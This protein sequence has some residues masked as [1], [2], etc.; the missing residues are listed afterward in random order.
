MPTVEDLQK[1]EAE[2]RNGHD[3]DADGEG[4][5]IE[6]MEAAGIVPDEDE[7]PEVYLEG[8]TGQLSLS[9]GG[10]KPDSATFKM[11]AK[12]VKLAERTQFA[13]GSTVKLHVIARVDEL[14]FRDKHDDAG[15][16]SHTTRVHLGIPISVVRMSATDS[17]E[18]AVVDFLYESDFDTDDDPYALMRALIEQTIVRVQEDREID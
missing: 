12:E 2:A 7:K 18:A 6:D 10:R 17:L 14:K 16:V 1:M 5:S 11:G 15:E 13:K 3:P 8:T 9:V 4:M